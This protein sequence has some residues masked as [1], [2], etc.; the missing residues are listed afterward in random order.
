MSEFRHLSVSD[1][2]GVVTCTM[3]NP[4]R[5]TLVAAEVGELD[6]LVGSL[7]ARD[8]VR[9]LVFTGAAAGVFIAHYEVGELAVSAERSSAAPARAPAAAPELHA[10]HRFILRLQRA[11]FV[12]IA[13]IA[14]SFASCRTSAAGTSSTPG[15]G[16]GVTTYGTHDTAVI[17]VPSAATRTVQPCS[18]CSC[19]CSSNHVRT[20]VLVGSTFQSHDAPSTIDEYTAGS[21]L[22]GSLAA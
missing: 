9:V 16:N 13:R 21:I 11:S 15:I 22:Q 8:D 19:S 5:H 2:N 6:R 10:F 20:R 12:T 18:G 7:E 4:P 14:A 17:A 3:S 1:A